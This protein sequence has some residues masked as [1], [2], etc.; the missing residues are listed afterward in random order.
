MKKFFTLIAAALLAVNVSAQTEETIKFLSGNAAWA[1]MFVDDG[2]EYAWPGRTFEASDKLTAK[3]LWAGALLKDAEDK[4]VTFD[5]ESGKT[6]TYT[7]EFGATPTIK[8]QMCVNC[9]IPNQYGGGNSTMAYK[10]LEV[11]DNVATFTVSAEDCFFTGKG[12]KKNDK[13]EWV[14][15]KEYEKE[16]QNVTSITLQACDQTADLYPAVIN[17]KSIKRVTSTATG[18]SKVESLE[19]AK[20]GKSFNLAG[21][22]VGKGYKG[23]VIKNGKKVVVK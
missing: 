16:P 23:I 4:D 3:G 8:L 6:Q 12:Y 7:I 1:Q 21:Q 11:K 18:I 15:D 5:R 13:E 10:P 20:D 17:I 19:V 9:V 22:Q 2:V 14:L